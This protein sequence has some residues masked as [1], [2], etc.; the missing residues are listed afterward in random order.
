MKKDWLWADLLTFSINTQRDLNLIF[1]L[2][3]WLWWNSPILTG[4]ISIYS[5]QFLLID[6]KFKRFSSFFKNLWLLV[7]KENKETPF[8]HQ[9]FSASFFGKFIQENSTLPQ[10]LPSQLQISVPCSAISNLIKSTHKISKRL[11]LTAF[12]KVNSKTAETQSDSTYG[13]K[14]SSTETC[15]SFQQ[16]FYILIKFILYLISKSLFHVTWKFILFDFTV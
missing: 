8:I 2:T 10:L 13:D 11:S 15:D 7:S 4:V 12:K 3:L 16:I 14:F 5:H 9:N 1:N 6:S